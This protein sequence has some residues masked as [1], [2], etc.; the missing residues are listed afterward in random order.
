VITEPVAPEML[1]A[2]AIYLRASEEARRR[3]DRRTGTDHILLALLEDPSVEAMVGVNL[4]QA[5]QALDSL[6]REALAAVGLGPG[7]DAPP[8]PMRAVPKKPRIRD[9]AKRDRFRMTP[10]AKKV[11]EEAYKPK[12]HR[13]LQVT[14]PEVLAQILALQ[15]PDPAAVLLDALGVNTSALRRQL[16]LPSEAGHETDSDVAVAFKGRKRG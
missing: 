3:G 14:G 5:R 9:V 6:D 7:I 16:D 15:P 13:K 11:L 12:G 10:A 2:W 4:Q 8:L 1:H